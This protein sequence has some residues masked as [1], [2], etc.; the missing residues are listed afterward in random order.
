M[1]RLHFERLLVILMCAGLCGVSASPAPAL[2]RPIRHAAVRHG[3]LHHLASRTSG[4]HHA[5]VIRASLA[6]L[7]VRA[8][9][10][11]DREA[12]AYA[13]CS[14]APEPFVRAAA[15]NA[16]SLEDLTW[17][18]FGQP[19]KG[20][21]IYDL[22]VGR[23]IGAVCGSGTPIFAEKL[24]AFQASHQLP[25]DGVFTPATF[26][27]VKGLLQESRP[28][29]MARLAK[30]C[31]EAPSGAE[32]VAIPKEAETFER[33]GRMIRADV[34]AAYR[35][36]VAA[37]RAELP[38][39]KDDPKALTIF[40]AYR[41]PESDAA[42][43]DEQG[44]CDGLRRA[45]CSSHRT[46]TAID[47]N[48]GWISGVAADSTSPENRLLQTR[49]APYRWL[50]MN[51]PRFGFVNY[52]YEPWHWEWI[53]A[54]GKPALGTLPPPAIGPAETTTA[55]APATSVASPVTPPAL[56]AQDPH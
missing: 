13:S 35:R 2:A 17:T 54:P 3:G 53:G 10:E 28:F 43:C 12:H 26:E 39:L 49:A 22:L 38:A 8:E 24:A 34:F 55:A 19:E 20:W 15:V 52:P 33:E 27:V 48:V 42:R 16:R 9:P 31:P 47:I 56:K 36:M 30:V 25:A 46:G 40:S 44:N 51:A 11:P 6:R 32:L 14:D 29:V 50:V 1:R 7:A 4:R 41:S 45:A 37:A 18:P 23:E 5:Q 21:Q